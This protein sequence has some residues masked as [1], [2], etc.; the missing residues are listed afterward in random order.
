[1]G[2]KLIQLGIIWLC[3]VFAYIIMAFSMPALS[4]IVSVSSE[5]LSPTENTTPYVKDAVD[6]FPFYVWFIPGFVGIVTT[7]VVLKR[8]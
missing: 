7:V 4:E 1:M 3:I 6:A 2:N 8:D 5:E